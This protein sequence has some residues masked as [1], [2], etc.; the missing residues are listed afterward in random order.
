MPV[1][2]LCFGGRDFASEEYRY[3][4]RGSG[5]GIKGLRRAYTKGERLDVLGTRLTIEWLFKDPRWASRMLLLNA[6]LVPR[7]KSSSAARCL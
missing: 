7:I 5:P 2:G 1:F 4:P 6:F 3:R